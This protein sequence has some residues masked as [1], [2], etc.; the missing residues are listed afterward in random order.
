MS[1]LKRQ[2]LSADGKDRVTAS[3]GGLENPETVPVSK[4]PNE[5]LERIQPGRSLF[6]LSLPAS[7]TTETL[8]EHFSQK[9]PIKHATVVVDPGTN[10]SKGYG[11]VTFADVDDAQGAIE[12]FN[13]TTFEGQKIKVELAQPRQRQASENGPSNKTKGVS[14]KQKKPE[15]QPRPKL[16]VRNLPW[17]IKEPE[18]LA[19]LFRNYGKVKHATMP[20]KKPGLSAGFGF[21][22]LRG[23]KNA[24]KALEGV[25][26]KKIE[27][28]TLAVDWA[29]DK[30]I[31]DKAQDGQS[32]PENT[33]VNTEAT[34][35]IEDV[36]IGENGDENDKA[37]SDMS[38]SDEEGSQG[39]SEQSEGSDESE[40]RALEKDP[41]T[42]FIRNLPFACLEEDLKE[43]FQSFGPVRY[44]R[45]VLDQATERSKG[46]AFVCFFNSQDADACLR[47]APRVQ[48]LSSHA[49]RPD[50]SE[51]SSSIKQSLL[52][53]T[54]K[55]LSG[56]F[57]I[58]GRVLQVS[59]A[60]DRREATR[61]T[62]AGNNLRDAR[63][64]DK[65]RLYLLA[66]GTVA[67]DTPLYSLLS[68]TEMKVRED[69]NRQKQSLLRSNPSLHLSLTRLSIRNLPRSINSKDLKALAREAVVNFAK[70]VKS[71]A[72][73]SL[74]KEEES[75]GGE[76]M[77]NAE[78]ARK[79]KGKGIVKQAKV[80]FEG[81]DG[82]KA[83]EKSGAGRSRGYGFIEYSSHRWALMGLR[84]LNGHAVGSSGSTAAQ[85]DAR[86][87]KKRLIVEFAIDNAQVVERRREKEA[88]ARER[89][90]FVSDQC[91][92]GE[93]PVPPSK[94]ALSKDQ[95]MAK[96]R[97]GMKRKRSPGSEPVEQTNTPTADSTSKDPD[98]SSKRQQIIGRKRMM[99]KSRGKGAPG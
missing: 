54:T 38:A 29:V 59:Q 39:V 7:V 21:V 68:T 91:D 26:G 4:T 13:Q 45:I 87:R 53:D 24:E 22:V 90:R 82:G 31:W 28:R 18:Q 15:F 61:L 78:K 43:H 17:T 69:V 58:D 71:G 57:T 35:D 97:K 84:W 10:K 66:E 20:T 32:G 85:T 34:R 9:F 47:E 76:D 93:I 95:M 62:C 79:A 27:G 1:R 80:Q 86:E 8:A 19:A 41:P 83:A 30:A 12:A 48:P 98:K 42:L 46:T 73:K 94:K 77:R 37:Q 70:D 6:V 75:R 72:R 40:V 3:D 51:K 44:A 25:N 49:G 89:S 74:S 56:R 11:F 99:R 65:R 64:K 55:D 92:K 60:V 2:R 14:Q 88:K 52:E 63:D 16:I 81:R 23:R 50:R 36:D 67:P 5:K 96:T 33:D